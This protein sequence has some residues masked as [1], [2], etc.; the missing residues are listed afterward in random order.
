MAVHV[1]TV[2]KKRSRDLFAPAV[3]S[4]IDKTHL[5]SAID[6]GPR[7]LFQ[8]IVLGTRLFVSLQTL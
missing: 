6:R 3:V 1:V 8:A 4:S 2:S 7:G 5:P